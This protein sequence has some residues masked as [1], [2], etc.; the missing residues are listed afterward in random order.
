MTYTDEQLQA[1]QRA[2]ASGELEV[3]YADRSVTYR[4][5]DELIKAIAI[6]KSNLA[7]PPSPRYSFTGFNRD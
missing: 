5:V 3:R 4:S 1:L 2:L 6:V 7:T